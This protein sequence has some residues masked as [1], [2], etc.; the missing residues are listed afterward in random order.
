MSKK[1]VILNTGT[2]ETVTK[3]VLNEGFGNI[4][5]LWSWSKE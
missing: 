3:Q 1:N 2:F 4:F 5:Y